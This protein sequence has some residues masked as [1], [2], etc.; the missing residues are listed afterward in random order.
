MNQYN[1]MIDTPRMPDLLNAM[2]QGQQ[3]AANRQ[4]YRM[5]QMEMQ[6]AEE[7][8]RQ[9][10]GF[11]SAMADL[12]TTTGGDFDK[13]AQLA[14]IKYGQNAPSLIA[15]FNKMKS[16]QFG[17]QDL[18]MGRQKSKLEID[19]LS[20]DLQGQQREALTKVGAPMIREFLKLPQPQRLDAFG[21]F[22]EAWRQ[23]GLKVEPRWVDEGYTL[24]V[25]KELESL[26]QIPDQTKPFIT[27]EQRKELENLKQ[28]GMDRRASV[29]NRLREI[30]L[31]LKDRT[32]SQKQK[33]QLRESRK[34]DIELKSKLDGMENTLY[35]LD[36]YEDD[37]RQIYD[38]AA[39]WQN[40]GIGRG[41]EKIPGSEAANIKSKL[42]FIVNNLVV[43][44]VAEAKKSGVTFG[45]M[46]ESEWQQMKNAVANLDPNQSPEQYRESVGRLLE[47]IERSKQLVNNDIKSHEEFLFGGSG[48]YNPDEFWR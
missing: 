18:N 48:S 9:E 8:Q 7:A 41:F 39:L 29:T 12:L 11:R 4:A 5:N 46:T 16:D 47:R 25:G 30:D 17:M 38:D 6:K 35:K 37:A 27:F 45:A 33:Q 1:Y 43:D 24:G 2:S 34:Q 10:Q 42:G 19:K 3:M 32:L 44:A 26:A 15:A 13:A 31:G 28:S 40:A 21:P 14:P 20:S 22:T 23:A 36:V